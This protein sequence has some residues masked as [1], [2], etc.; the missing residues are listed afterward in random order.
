MP[1]KR[2]NRLPLRTANER[3]S[4]ETIRASIGRCTPSL[5][6]R[7]TTPIERVSP[8]VLSEDEIDES[9]CEDY[10]REDDDEE[11]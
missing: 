1:P 2:T 4:A 3:G 6:S 9:E 10:N 11:P 8:R 5:A 7:I